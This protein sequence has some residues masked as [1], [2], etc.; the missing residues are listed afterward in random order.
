MTRCRPALLLQRQRLGEL[1]HLAGGEVE[2][3]GA[4]ARVDVEP[5][6]GELARGRGVERR[7]SDQAG[8]GEPRLVAETDV[9][10]DREVGQQRLLLEHHADAVAGGV[11]GAGEAR[12]LAAEQDR[13]GVGLV[14]AGQDAHQRRLAG[15]VLADQAHDLVRPDLEADIA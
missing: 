12:R 10:A 2:V 15:A 11:G 9:L 4:H 13:A 6:L 5:D 1:D 14:D 7:A 8:A 3:G